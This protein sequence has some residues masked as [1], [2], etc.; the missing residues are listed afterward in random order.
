MA[1]LVKG[2]ERAEN[3]PENG[4]VE[5]DSR[6]IEKS[7]KSTDLHQLHPIVSDS[8]LLRNDE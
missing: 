7:A 5:E 4:N 3:V 8:E 6:V 2:N 1:K